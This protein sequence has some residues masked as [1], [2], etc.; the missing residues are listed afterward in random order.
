[1]KLVCKVQEHLVLAYRET[2]T[3]EFFFVLCREGLEKALNRK[4]NVR[5]KITLIVDVKEES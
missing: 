3:G 1:M 4:L 5:D 2:D